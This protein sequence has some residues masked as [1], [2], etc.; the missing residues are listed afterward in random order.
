VAQDGLRVPVRWPGGDALLP[1]HGLARL[2][3]RFEGIR[4]ED[5]CLHAVYVASED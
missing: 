3:L 2:Q 5:G 4:A 1:S